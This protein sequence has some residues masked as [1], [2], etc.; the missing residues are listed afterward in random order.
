MHTLRDHERLAVE[1]LLA[2]DH[3]VLAKLRD[4]TAHATASK[5]TYSTAGEYVDLT[6]PAQ[7]E[8]ISPADLIL[9]D[10]ELVFEGVKDGAAILLYIEGGRLSFIEFATYGVEWPTNPKVLGAH[11]LREIQTQPGTYVYEPVRVR[12]HAPNGRVALPLRA[13]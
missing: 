5:R 3:E 8:L 10:I 1:M 12:D 11:Y 13:G 2:G 4:Q 9:Q 6:V 7:A